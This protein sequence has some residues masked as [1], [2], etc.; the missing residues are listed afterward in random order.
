MPGTTRDEDVC[1]Q[2]QTS[3]S[4]AATSRLE[5]TPMIKPNET[6]DT[7]MKIGMRPF[8]MKT[9]PAH[10]GLTAIGADPRG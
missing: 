10:G 4:S 7:K 2:L 3:V 1:S 6:P 9:R 5:L 8:I